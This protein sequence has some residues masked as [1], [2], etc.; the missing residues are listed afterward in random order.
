MRFY[1][2]L[3]P[4]R[5]IVNSDFLDIYQGIYHSSQLQASF[6]PDCLQC[7]KECKIRGCESWNFYLEFVSAFFWRK[8]HLKLD[9][10]LTEICD[11]ASKR[12]ITINILGF[13]PKEKLDSVDFFS[14]KK[15]PPLTCWARQQ[16]VTEPS[17]GHIQYLFLIKNLKFLYF[18]KFK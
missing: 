4:T 12:L 17:C 9:K 2:T 1:W 8:V 15:G 13:I 7:R 6:I 10:I 14:L 11:Y 18:W 3:S 5:Q 16:T